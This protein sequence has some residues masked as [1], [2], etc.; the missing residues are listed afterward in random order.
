MDQRAGR[1]C[2]GADGYRV[3]GEHVARLTPSLSARSSTL[4]SRRSAR[5]PAHL[6]TGVPPG[7]RR[8]EA[9]EAEK[10]ADGT[11]RCRS[12]SFVSRLAGPAAGTD[13]SPRSEGAGAME[14]QPKSL[15]RGTW[16]G[17]ASYEAGDQV[18]VQRLAVDRLS[19][20]GREAREG[21]MKVLRSRRDRAHDGGGARPRPADRRGGG[22]AALLAHNRAALIRQGIPFA[23]VEAM[24]EMQ[25]EHRRRVASYLARSPRMAR[26]GQPAP[27]A[28]LTPAEG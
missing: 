13:R 16:S 6:I 9:A 17:A 15:Y 4:P 5:R 10:L 21:G 27:M 18:D 24:A 2:H 11:R 3:G 19:G 28:S 7:T 25:R 20:V 14:S 23:A 8:H 12:R 26:R 1:R 22:G